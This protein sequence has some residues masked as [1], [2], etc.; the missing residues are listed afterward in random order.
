MEDGRWDRR[1]CSCVS[2]YVCMCVCVYVCLL[3]IFGDAVCAVRVAGRKES[4]EGKHCNKVYANTHPHSP[5]LTQCEPPAQ[6]TEKLKPD[7]GKPAEECGMGAR[8][9]QSAT[10]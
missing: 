3:N 8:L 1:G 6:I 7:L 4:A 5:F 9:K 10:P 2:V